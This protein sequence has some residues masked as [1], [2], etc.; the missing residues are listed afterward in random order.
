MPE[1]TETILMC[2]LNGRIVFSVVVRQSFT[3]IKFNPYF[4]EE[5]KMKKK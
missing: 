5:K 4:E 1:N 2:V 3:Y